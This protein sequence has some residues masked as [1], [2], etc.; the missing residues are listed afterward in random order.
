MTVTLQD[1]YERTWEGGF[2]CESCTIHR[3]RSLL[4]S[5]KVSL[6]CPLLRIKHPVAQC[7]QGSIPGQWL[8]VTRTG[9]SAALDSAALPSRSSTRPRTQVQRY[10]ATPDAS[11]SRAANTQTDEA[12]EALRCATASPVARLSSLPDSGLT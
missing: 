11:L 5:F 8:A 1:A 7:L 12:V 10:Q 9:I 4:P 6:T 2:G 3:S